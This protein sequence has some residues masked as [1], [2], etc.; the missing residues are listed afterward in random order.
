VTAGTHNIVI[1]QGSTFRLRLTLRLPAVVQGEPGELMDLSGHIARMHI[2]QKVASPEIILALTSENGGLT[3]G[4]AA[5]TIDLFI[6][7]EDTAS[8]TIRSG[9]YDLEIETVPDGDVTRII[10]GQVQV[11]PE[12]TR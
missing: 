10:Q 11:S 5:G 4:G 3:L 7:D 9:V 8:L 1:E 12:V 2:R 6:S